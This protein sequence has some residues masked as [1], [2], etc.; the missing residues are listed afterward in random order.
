MA[1]QTTLPSRNVDKRAYS[2]EWKEQTGKYGQYESINTEKIDGGGQWFLDLFDSA[3]E[4][5]Y[6]YDKIGVYKYKRN[7]NWIN[8]FRKSKADGMLEEAITMGMPAPATTGTT[9]TPRSSNQDAW[10]ERDAKK[11]EQIQKLH[12][13]TVAATNKNTESN[14]RLA[15]ELANVRRQVEDLC[16]VM[17]DI[18]KA[19]ERVAD[20]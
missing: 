17:A 8:R 6:V 1:E 9:A 14:F 13:E 5:G 12:D 11:S 7:G 18:R 4:K 3:D 15:D 16:F 2:L 19:L 20:K 10:A